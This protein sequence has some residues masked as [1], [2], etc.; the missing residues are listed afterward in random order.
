MCGLTSIDHLHQRA[1]FSLYV[2]PQYRKRGYAKETL[3]TLFSYG[4]VALNLNC[5]WGETFDGNPAAKIFE[6]VG[7]VREGTR[8][9]FYFKKGKFIDC[10]LYSVKRSEWAYF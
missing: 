4:F 5:I 10:H 7:M 9:D 2:G 3:K 1:E 8:R 6:S